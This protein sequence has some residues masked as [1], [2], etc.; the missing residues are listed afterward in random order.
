MSVFTLYLFTLYP[1]PFV[2]TI[3]LP[4]LAKKINNNYD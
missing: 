1:A 3:I 2:D 4:N